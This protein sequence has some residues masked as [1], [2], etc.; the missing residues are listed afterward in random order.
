MGD[1]LVTTG[2]VRRARRPVVVGLMRRA[3]HPPHLSGHL[4]GGLA[5]VGEAILT[6]SIRWAGD[7]SVP[8]FAPRLRGALIE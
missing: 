8:P 4:P 7:L 6:L 3:P 2:H 1:H 5:D